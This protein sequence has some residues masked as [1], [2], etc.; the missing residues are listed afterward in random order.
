[1]ELRVCSI[2]VIIMGNEHDKPIS[3]PG[4]IYTFHLKYPLERTAYFFS[5]PSPDMDE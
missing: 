1:M 2:M 4:W 3:N 5:L